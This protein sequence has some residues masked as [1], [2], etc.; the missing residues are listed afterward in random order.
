MCFVDC[1]IQFYF[2]SFITQ[3]HLFATLYY[4]IK[5]FIMLFYSMMLIIIFLIMDV[6]YYRYQKFQALDKDGICK[7]NIIRSTTIFIS[8][9]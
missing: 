5:Q 4:S 8:H 1:Y 9:L 7:V 6:I 2:V 3:K